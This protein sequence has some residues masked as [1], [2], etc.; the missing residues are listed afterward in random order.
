MLVLLTIAFFAPPN[1]WDSMTYHMAR[2]AHW[3][4]NH[5]VDLYPTQDERQIWKDPWAE[6]AILHLQLL[7]QGDHY[8]NLVQWFSYA[9]SIIG[10]SLIARALGI[11]RLG[12]IVTALVAATMPMSLLQATS[13]QNDLAAA[14]WLI[15]FIDRKSTR[16]NSSHLKLSR[17]PSSA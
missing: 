15:C 2:V 3:I 17:M 5:R 6:Y 4:Q 7:S 12:Q 1:T 16:L 11:N 10:V 14:L 9:G 8:A 13:T